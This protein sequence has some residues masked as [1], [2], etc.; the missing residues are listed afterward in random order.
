MTIS[1]ISCTVLELQVHYIGNF[2][3]CM[4]FVTKMCDLKLNI[5]VKEVMEMKEGNKLISFIILLIFKF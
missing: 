4:E 1:S 3:E 5:I 2:R